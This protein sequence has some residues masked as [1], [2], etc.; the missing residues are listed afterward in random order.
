MAYKKPFHLKKIYLNFFQC[1]IQLKLDILQE[2]VKDVWLE[3]QDRLDPKNGR[4]DLVITQIFH[5]TALSK[6]LN[7]YV[8]T[9]AE[10]SLTSSFWKSYPGLSYA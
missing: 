9:L 1:S 2:L 3:F 8:K 10:M 6:F 5:A 7:F 4:T